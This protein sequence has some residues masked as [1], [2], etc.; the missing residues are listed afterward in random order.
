LPI[1]VLNSHTHDDHV[2]NNW[3]FETIYGMDTEFT[4]ENARGSREDAQA[5]VTPDQIYLHLPERFDPK[6]YA[7][8]PWE[9]TS[10]S[11]DGDRIDLGGRSL[12]I[13]ATPGHT[14]I[15]DS[16]ISISSP[17]PLTVTVSAAL[18]TDIW[19]LASALWFTSTCTPLLVCLAKDVALAEIA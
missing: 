7:T 17:P 8:R 11:H 1:V 6:T 12:K 5:E 10:F 18:P 14:P 2:G 4:R 15:C 9:I 19:K 16:R 3:Q 13:I